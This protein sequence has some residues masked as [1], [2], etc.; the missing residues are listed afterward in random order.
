MSAFGLMTNRTDRNLTIS[1]LMPGKS[2]LTILDSLNLIDVGRNDSQR[3]R[4]E[5]L[6][7]IGSEKN[8]A[9]L[10]FIRVGN[11]GIRCLAKR[12]NVSHMSLWRDIDRLRA[13]RLIETWTVNCSGKE[14][15]VGLRIIPLSEW[16][17]WLSSARAAAHE[18][19]RGV[20]TFRQSTKVM[21][22]ALELGSAV[23]P[24]IDSISSAS[25]IINELLKQL[26]R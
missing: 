4:W 16:L 25:R 22:L 8:G 2:I 18:C 1:D 6:L 11:G 10:G 24:T 20:P 7:Q 17:I 19:R 9:S 14:V 26:D 13:K 5:L 15:L 3:H 21:H 12:M 23:P